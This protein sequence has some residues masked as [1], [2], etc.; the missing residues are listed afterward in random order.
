M[1]TQLSH[2]GF[3]RSTRAGTGKEEQHCQDF[4]P[5]IWMQLAQSAFPFEVKRDIQ[6]GFNFFLAEVKVPD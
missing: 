4:V 2:P 6:D 1:T 5:Q 3:K